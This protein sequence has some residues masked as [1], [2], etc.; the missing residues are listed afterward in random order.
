MFTLDTGYK[1]HLYP[2]IETKRFSKEVYAGIVVDILTKPSLYCFYD[3]N[4]REIAIEGAIEYSFDLS[5][6]LFSGLGIDMK[7]N[8]GHYYAEKPYGEPISSYINST[9]KYYYYGTE[10]NLVYE[11]DHVRIKVGVSYAGN[12]ASKK[13]WFNGIYAKNNMWFNASINCSF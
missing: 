2:G 12:A 1:C 8:V 11:L 3:F 6:F 10:V 13:S 4:H 7:V 9:N 5:P